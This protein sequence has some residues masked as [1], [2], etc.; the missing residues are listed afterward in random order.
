MANYVITERARRALSALLRGSNGNTG[1]SAG[2]PAAVSFDAFPLPFTVRWSAKESAWV[3]W[4]PDPAGLLLVEDSAETITGITASQNLPAGWYTIDA[5]GS[6][7]TSIYLVI[8][9]TEASGTTP[10][11]TTV[12]L[13][14]SAGSASTGEK[15]YNLLVAAIATNATTG[16][17]T[18]KQY[19][20]SAVT[21]GGGG[22]AYWETGGDSTTCNADEIMVGNVLIYEV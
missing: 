21:I 7:S 22:G 17:K 2:G 6:S 3:I 18:V 11:S 5:L 19:L 14:D 12:E 9:K 10:A 16:A 20:S 15:V 1:G 13:L 8:T 4:L